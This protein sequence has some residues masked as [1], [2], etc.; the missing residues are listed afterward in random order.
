MSPLTASLPLLL[1]FVFLI[2]G[3][4]Q[5]IMMLIY[6]SL[7][8]SDVENFLIHLLTICVSSLT[9]VYSDNFIPNFVLIYLGSVRD[10]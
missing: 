10:H 7:L 9:D 5:L 6:V 2:T 8:C 3:V 4:I 1:T